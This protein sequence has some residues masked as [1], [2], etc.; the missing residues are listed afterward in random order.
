MDMT[1]RTD[2]AIK[3][4]GL[5][6]GRNIVGVHGAVPDAIGVDDHQRPMVAGVL[7]AGLQQLHLVF[8]SWRLMHGACQRGPQSH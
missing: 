5:E 3:D 7:A 6:D 2:L 8:E 4:M 1:V